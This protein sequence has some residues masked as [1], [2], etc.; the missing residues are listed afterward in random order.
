ME[1]SGDF[2]FRIGVEGRDDFESAVSEE[3]DGSAMTLTGCDSKHPTLQA[4]W[5]GRESIRCLCVHS[6]FSAM[7]YK[8]G[9]KLSYVVGSTSPSIL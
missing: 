7:R 3:L 6:C 9:L 8:I 1:E 5:V 4:I 2:G